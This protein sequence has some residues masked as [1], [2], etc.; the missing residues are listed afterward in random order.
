MATATITCEP[1]RSRSLGYRT[2][3]SVYFA[4]LATLAQHRDASGEIVGY[5]VNVTCGGI[6][7]DYQEFGYLDNAERYFDEL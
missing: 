4:I 6:G 3:L 1:I 2:K 7:E 5:S